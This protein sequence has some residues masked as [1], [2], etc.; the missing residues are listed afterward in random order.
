MAHTSNHKTQEI[1]VSQT[2]E[3]K[4]TLA[5][6]HNDFQDSHGD[7][8]K[9]CLQK[10]KAKQKQQNIKLWLNIWYFGVRT[11]TCFQNWYSYFT[12]FSA[13]SMTLIMKY[14]LA[15]MGLEPFQKHLL[16]LRPLEFFLSIRQIK[17]L[18]V[19]FAVF[20]V[21]SWRKD[22]QE[23]GQRQRPTSQNHQLFQQ[24]MPQS[25][26]LAK[27]AR[28]RDVCMLCVQNQGYKLGV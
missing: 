26:I 27:P 13:E 23:P 4:T 19:S 2:S 10:L 5:T 28:Q 20:P 9:P 1:E 7:T 18:M 11:S 16:S 17:L 21:H 14:K 15:E 3:I 22:G 8:K 24:R 25:Q 12:T 6:L